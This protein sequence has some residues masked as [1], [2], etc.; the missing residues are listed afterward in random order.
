MMQ[1][2]KVTRMAFLN[3]AIAL[4]NIILFSPGLLAIKITG[5][6]VFATAFGITVIFMSFLVFFLGNYIILT[7]KE[8]S[9][10]AKEIESREDCIYALEQNQNKKTFASDIQ[11]ILEQIER[12]EKKKTTIRDILL[13]KFDSNEMSYGKFYGSV[14]NVEEIFFIN[15]KSIINKINAFDEDDYNKIK[16]G[17]LTDKFSKEFVKAKLDIYNEYISFVKASLE[18]NEEIILQLDR[19]LLEISN[20]N[21]LEEGEIENM[22]ALKEIGELIKKARL[23]K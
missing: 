10:Q 22:E 20:F 23:Y 12:V 6:T 1:S 13:Q 8:R 19:L 14:L 7:A 17:S 16:T 9:I 2:K 5:S 18:D 11:I 15:I 3:I 21:S 4:I